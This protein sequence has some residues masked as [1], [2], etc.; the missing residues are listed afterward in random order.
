MWLFEPFPGL[1]ILVNIGG[2]LGIWAYIDFMSRSID[3]DNYTGVE[4]WI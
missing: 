2:G 3:V 4:R 1:G